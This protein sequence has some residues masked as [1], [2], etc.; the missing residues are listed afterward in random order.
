MGIVTINLQKYKKLRIEQVAEERWKY[1]IGGCVAPLRGSTLTMKTDRESRGVLYDA[2]SQATQD[3]EGRWLWK[4][5][6][7]W[8]S[9]TAE[10]IKGLAQA[11]RAHVQGAYDREAACV[12]AIRQA[13][14]VEQ[15]KNI[16][17]G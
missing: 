16:M 13:T 14:T 15:V 12:E 4:T 7:G 5:S 6:V 1:E 3:P 10:E 11:V 8:L 17:L 2:A 9:L